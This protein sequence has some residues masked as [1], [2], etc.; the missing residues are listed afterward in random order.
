VPFLLAAIGGTGPLL[1]SA[2]FGIDSTWPT[3]GGAAGASIALAALLLR[4]INRNSS[5]AWRI[6]QDKNRTI[7]RMAWV[8][9]VKERRIA[10]LE[11]ELRICRGIASPGTDPDVA[12]PGPYVAPT[13]DELRSW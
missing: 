4:E 13:E 10:V 2:I 1:V 6:V 12:D 8:D 3:I 9:A 5:G 11:T 7:H